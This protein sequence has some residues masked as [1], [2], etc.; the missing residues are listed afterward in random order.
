MTTA[1]QMQ[2]AALIPDDVWTAAEAEV[3]DKS[4]LKALRY[5]LEAAGE[6]YRDYAPKRDRWLA[7]HGRWAPIEAQSRV[8]LDLLPEDDE[9][10]AEISKLLD[11]ASEKAFRAKYMLD[12]LHTHVQL[13]RFVDESDAPQLILYRE[14]IALW[15]EAG[16]AVKRT[17]NSNKEGGRCIRFLSLILGALMGEKAPALSTLGDIVRDWQAEAK[18]LLMGDEV[19]PNKSLD[20][21]LKGWE[22]EG[23]PVS[24]NGGSVVVE[25]L[26]GRTTITRV[27]AHNGRDRRRKKT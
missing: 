22:D 23:E 19:P 12:D 14:V 4:N 13:G 1:G 8:L 11:R 15:I 7:E 16:G 9:S 18:W 2:D 26:A 5:Q 6:R 17:V 27:P 21:I 24:L 10:R 20:D 3:S 25:H